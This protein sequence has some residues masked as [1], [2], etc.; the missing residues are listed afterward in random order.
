MPGSHGSLTKAGKVR[1]Q[2]PQVETKRTPGNERADYTGN[3]LNN[4]EIVWVYDTTNINGVDWYLVGPNEWVH[5]NV[6][7]RV[8]PNPTPPSGINGERWIEIA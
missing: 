7:A 5:Q 8:I 3:L 4:H 6:I 1:S 2:T